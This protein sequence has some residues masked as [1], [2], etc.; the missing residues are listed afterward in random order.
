[1]KKNHI[2]LLLFALLSLFCGTA[3][4]KVVNNQ[5]NKSNA[6]VSARYITPDGNRTY[7]ATNEGIKIGTR[8]HKKDW[9]W[10]IVTEDQGL[11]DNNV[12][13]LAIATDKNGN[14]TALFAASAN[15]D[16]GKG[17]IS[18]VK[19]DGSGVYWTVD[20]NCTRQPEDLT[21]SLTQD[22]AGIPIALFA[23]TGEGLMRL[24]NLS[25]DHAP[26][27]TQWIDSDLA[28]YSVLVTYN[29][30]TGTPV[31]LYALNKVNKKLL[32]LYDVNPV[33][34]SKKKLT[35][36]T[37]TQD[38]GSD[39]ENFL[40]SLVAEMFR[41]NKSCQEQGYYMGEFEF[42]LLGTVYW[43]DHGQYVK[44]TT[45][46]YQYYR[47]L[48]TTNG[49][50]EVPKF[51]NKQ[52]EL[53]FY[54]SLQNPKTG[55]FMDNTYPLC[56]YTGPTSN[57]LVLLDELAS[58]TGEKLKYP[59]TYLD[60]VNTPKKM[61]SYLDDVSTIGKIQLKFPQTTFHQARDMLSLFY[62]DTDVVDKY[63]LYN[64]PPKTKKALLE[65]FYENQDHK[66][67]LWGPKN[68]KGELV[69]KDTM[70]SASIIKAFVDEN[71]D[72]KYPKEFPLR[73]QKHLAESFLKE[74][75]KSLNKTP[76]NQ[77]LMQWHEWN[78]NVAKSMRTLTVYLWKNLSNNSRRK[79]KNLIEKYIR[80]KFQNFYVKKDG[81]FSYYPG[82]KHATLDGCGF[83]GNLKDYGY[84]S[85]KN[86][87]KLWNPSIEK[88]EYNIS[89][90]TK[91]DFHMDLNG[92]NSIRFYAKD[93]QAENCIDNYIHNVFGV[94]YPQKTNIPDA[95][96]LIPRMQHWLDNTKQTMGNWTSK[97]SIQAIL[98]TTGIKS[99]TILQQNLPVK[100][101][102][103]VLQNNDRLVLIGFDIL[104]I[105]RV[106]IVY[107]RI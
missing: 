87:H 43:L 75:A 80:I 49:L 37:D 24:S 38:I 69:K 102:N 53:K 25:Q 6:T 85:A 14:V 18:K 101:L 76:K 94:F 13:D 39:F 44:A 107:N 59:L 29:H 66:T 57:V 86:Q 91:A 63:G 82:S 64:M 31:K 74:I 34:P 89:N 26:A 103:D 30:S 8:S 21:L 4:A 33:S 22:S 106:K 48:K 99:T 12:N 83:V 95:M 15:I 2:P 68:T 16:S 61:K 35:M 27:T 52:A 5:A 98:I 23:K 88:K 90:F 55:A 20:V 60:K 47:Q 7:L 40:Q 71:G 50:I 92:I 62:E 56:E 78:L 100:E 65:W 81:A 9:S 93:P 28:N 3:D 19:L 11:P 41:L 36:I 54:L 70:N 67:G 72:D 97:A 46:T 105:P 104:Q 45:K 10:K 77:D 73:Y 51:K 58:A 42:K 79:T 96:D 32:Y 84:C 17:G 1:M